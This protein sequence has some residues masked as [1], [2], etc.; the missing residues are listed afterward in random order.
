MSRLMC[1]EKPDLDLSLFARNWDNK[2]LALALR[3]RRRSS[4]VSWDCLVSGDE[5]K[6]LSP[7][8]CYP[9]PTVRSLLH[10]LR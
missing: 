10:V 4:K 9:I 1:G 3:G 5:K 2:R 7:L 8:I 6:S